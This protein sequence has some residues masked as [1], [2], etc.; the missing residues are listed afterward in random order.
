MN[1]L[2]FTEFVYDLY[3]KITVLIKVKYPKLFADFS[4]TKK[5]RLIS[6]NLCLS[7]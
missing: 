3:A 6:K 4:Q 2:S 1:L 7:C 5:I